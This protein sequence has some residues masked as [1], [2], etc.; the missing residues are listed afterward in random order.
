MSGASVTHTHDVVLAADEE[1]C[2]DD[3]DTGL[4][5]SDGHV[6]KTSTS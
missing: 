2:C 1:P 4:T 6:E 3:T 5:I